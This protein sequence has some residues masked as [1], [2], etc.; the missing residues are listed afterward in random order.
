[1]KKRYI[2]LVLSSLLTLFVVVKKLIGIFEFR[3]DENVFSMIKTKNDFME[4][5]LI[6]IGILLILISI[7]GITV[8][9]YNP[10]VNDKNKKSYYPKNDHLVENNKQ[11][12]GFEDL[13]S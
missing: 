9:L 7:V 10:Y 6:Y 13:Y 1:M 2:F 12:K 4:N 8:I 3:T 11:L 5:F